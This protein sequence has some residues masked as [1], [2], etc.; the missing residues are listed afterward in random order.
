MKNI[1]C[2]IPNIIGYVRLLLLLVSWFFL[3]QPPWF[4][5]FYLTSFFLD[6]VDGAVARRLHQTSA[7]GAW[8]DVAIDNF[9]RGM[10]WT[11]LFRWGYF[12]S[13]LEW[14][15]FVCTHT[16]GSQWKS[17]YSQAPWLIKN[18]MA[19][20]FKSL[21]GMYAIMSLD[22]LPVWFYVCRFGL[23]GSSVFIPR[24]MQY[25]GIAVLSGGRAVCSVVEGYCIWA[26]IQ[27]MISSDISQ[28]SSS[29]TEVETPES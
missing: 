3:K 9:G 15:T 8:L 4:L 23:Y 22:L 27:Q 21:L 6:F 17:S 25:I 29:L 12:V 14:C 16:A 2:Y 20:N 5:G 10:L 26:H 11:S 7:F 13:A 18:V 28:S 24:T 19:D 1:Y